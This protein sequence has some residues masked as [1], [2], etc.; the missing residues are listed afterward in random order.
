MCLL[1][2]LYD[3][4]LKV[5]CDNSPSCSTDNNTS[6][7]SCLFT[8]FNFNFAALLVVHQWGQLRLD[9]TDRT[10]IPHTQE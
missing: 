5:C 8:E 1:N 4:V 7:H 2:S 9:C 3:I 10:A 6:L